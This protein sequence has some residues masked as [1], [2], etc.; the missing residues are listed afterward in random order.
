M[1]KIHYQKLI[2]ENFES[3]IRTRYKFCKFVRKA[4]LSSEVLRNA[5][6]APVSENSENIFQARKLVYV[7]N[8]HYQKFVIHFEN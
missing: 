2:F 7:H 5:H 6:L 8:V 1:H 3:K 4:T